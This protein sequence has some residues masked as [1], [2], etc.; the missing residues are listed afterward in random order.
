MPDGYV[1]Y[2][3]PV[4]APAVAPLPALERGQLTLGLFQQSR[5]DHASSDPNLGQDSPSPAGGAAGAEVQ[6]MGQ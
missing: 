4:Y 5:Q 3:P 1:C 2:D 6:G